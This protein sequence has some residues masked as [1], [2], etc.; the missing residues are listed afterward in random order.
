MVQIH[1]PVGLGKTLDVVERLWMGLEKR[2]GIWNGSCLETQKR[3]GLE[4]LVVKRRGQQ[5]P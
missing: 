4:R 3:L 5:A 2:M 1:W